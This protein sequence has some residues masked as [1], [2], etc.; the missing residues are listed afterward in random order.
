MV[1][2]LKLWEISK[3]AEFPDLFIQKSQA[4]CHAMRFPCA[5]KGFLPAV[6]VNYTFFTFRLQLGVRSSE[7]QLHNEDTN[8]EKEGNIS[9][10]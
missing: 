6:L 10:S 4:V 8:A 3:T 7:F 9:I 5:G 1:A 2:S